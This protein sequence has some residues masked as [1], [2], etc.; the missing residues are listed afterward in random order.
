MPEPIYILNLLSET[1]D[2]ICK[3]ENGVMRLS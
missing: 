1:S 3:V 2:V